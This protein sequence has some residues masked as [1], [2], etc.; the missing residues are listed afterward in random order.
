ME[1]TIECYTDAS[2]SPQFDICVIGYKIGIH[3][4]ITNILPNIKNTQGEL[5]AID[6]CIYFCEN[7]YPKCK[8]IIHT[9]CQR[10]TQNKY[11]NT[12][13]IKLDGHKKKILKDDKDK[14]FSIVDKRVRQVLRQ[15]IKCYK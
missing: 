4:V 7:L 10:A 9:D 3:D 6:E 14:I 5:L 8:I 1:N 12:T 11:D 15:T 13:I 2:Y